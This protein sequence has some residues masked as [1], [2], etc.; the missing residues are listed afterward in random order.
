MDR[1]VSKTKYDRNQH[2]EFYK[3]HLLHKSPSTYFIMLIS[4]F[5]LYIAISNTIKAIETREGL[6]QIWILWALAAFSLLAAPLMM[7]SRINGIVKKETKERQ[8]SYDTIEV[9]KSKIV[10]TCSVME[11]KAV[12][13]WHQIESIAETK[14]Y[15]YIYT[16][17]QTGIFIVKDDIIE[18]NVELFRKLAENNM[19]KN[20]KGKV[21][22]SKHFKV[23]KND[24]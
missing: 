4:V 7:V 20:K 8:D 18:G 12:F 19:R 14:K 23:S 24:R 16:G 15:I 5:V 22:Y 2:K 1:V 3:F 11:G 21:K 6:N 10:R 17:P 9:T 13:G